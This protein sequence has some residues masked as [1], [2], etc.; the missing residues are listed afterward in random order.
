ML[1]KVK[2]RYDGHSLRDL[3]E[4][5]TNG[6]IMAQKPD[7]AEIVASMKRA[8]ITEPGYI[9]WYETCYCPS[10]L[11]HERETVYNHFL[12]E[13]TTEEVKKSGEIEGGSFWELLAKSNSGLG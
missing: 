12:S 6:S 1:Y 8:K 11:Q 3:Y 4:R 13:I 7:G 2:A 10:P 9:E 5:L